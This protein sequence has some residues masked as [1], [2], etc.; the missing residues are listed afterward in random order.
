[1]NVL[2]LQITNLGPIDLLMGKSQDD[3]ICPINLMKN[4]IH[5]L[6]MSPWKFNFM[7]VQ[8]GMYSFL[9][10]DIQFLLRC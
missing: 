2:L 5:D 4:D 3:D 10:Y 7:P 8:C 1:M 6:G 9:K